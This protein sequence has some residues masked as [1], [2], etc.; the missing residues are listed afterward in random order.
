MPGPG[1][2]LGPYTIDAH[3]GSGG[4]ATVFRA[5]DPH[6][7]A[8]ALKMLHP[9]R[10]VDEEVR[11]FHREA[12]ALGRLSH[13]NVLTVF[14][15][16]IADGY[17]WLAME[18]VEGT[19]L[20]VLVEKW[21]VERPPDRFARVE[22]ILRGLCA[23][24]QYVHE[25]GLVHR[26]L[27]PG[28]VLIGRDGV[29][30][31]A[32]FGVVKDSRAVTTQLT[33]AGKLVGT[34]AFMAPEQITGEQVDARADLYAL[35]AVL[36][37]MLTGKRPI[38]AQS[39]AGYL[40][41]HLTETP[42]PPSE[43]DPAVPR[44]L[45][46]VCQRL[47]LKDPGQR[48]PSAMAVLEALERPEDPGALPPRGRE[49]EIGEWT[50]RL[51]QLRKGAGGLLVL[52]GGSGAGKSH[53]LR[54]LLELARGSGVPT[55]TG[56]VPPKKQPG[57]KVWA[58]DD[59]DGRPTADIEALCRT[60]RQRVSQE[61][62]ALLCV[63][64]CANPDALATLSASRLPVETLA[65]GPVDR[66]AVLGILRDRG[67]TGNATTILGKRL[68][69]ATEGQ[70]G[71][72]VAYLDALVA[73][74]W[75]EPV[76]DIL[77]PK[78]GPDEL[79]ALPL[80]IPAALGEALRKRLIGLPGEALEVVEV[81]AVLERPATPALIAMIGGE[82]LAEGLDGAT[83]AGVLRMRVEEDQD[84]VTFVAPSSGAVIRDGLAPARKRA[85]HAAIAAGLGRRRRR[86]ASLEVAEH[87]VGAGDPVQAWPLFVQ[88]ARAAARL[89]RHSE[90][91]AIAQK[92]AS[93]VGTA[94]PA[95]PAD[96]RARNVRWMA[97][98]EGE[99][100]LSRGRW[101]DAV[102]RLEPAVTAAREEGD[103]AALSRCLASLGRAEYR[104]GKYDRAR[105]LL[106]E[107]LDTGD[108]GAPERA[109]ATRALADILLR[110]GDLVQS[111][112]LWSEALSLAEGAHSRDGEARARRG[113][114]HVRA[115]Q[116]RLEDAARMLDL[117][118]DLLASGGDDHVRAGVLARATELDLVAGRLGHALRRVDALVDLVVRRELAERIAEAHA[119]L[120]HVRYYVGE[121]QLAI[122]AAKQAMVY[123][124]AASSPHPRWRAARV[125]LATQGV[126]PRELLASLPRPDEV[127]T[128]AFDDAPAA[129]AGVRARALV[130]EN[131]DQA[132]DLAT[133]VLARSGTGLGFRTA[134]T[135]LDAARA[136]L[137]AG[138][139]EEA[140][141][142]AKR[143]IRLLQTL[144]P[145][146][147]ADGLVLDALILLDEANP[148]AR[149]REAA[150]QVIDR[151]QRL[152][153]PLVAA[154]FLARPEIR[155]RVIGAA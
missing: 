42:R 111:E 36:Y 13:P 46:R 51:E 17:P 16:G 153:P 27:K 10:V 34:V 81:L 64:T 147:S 149:V 79:R 21:D 91:L 138:A 40:A 22:R 108:H 86:E 29:P 98:L 30:K 110:E 103:R 109:S 112:A 121:R 114:A 3:L 55:T 139:R 52:S 85:L 120:A 99:A 20:G 68:H 69:E 105:P 33:M 39:V 49:A 89:G 151:I 106:R 127:G 150:G 93:I 5:H 113:L 128:A 122:E 136:L 74:G 97:M 137:H 116:G 77:R 62:E 154:S 131:A 73:D 61:G 134:A 53:L 145:P 19:D 78:R 50:R 58:I 87:L 117:T 9:S 31:I 63:V 95:T 92:V 104:R 84:V 83:R 57:P 7:R 26:D 60:L 107:A 2:R 35:G 118:E 45:E 41:R 100:L 18:L 124:R 8:V 80:P 44:K 140:K 12:R 6:G 54:H 1:S 133:W 25:Q 132:R 11:R 125:L 126:P 67:V 32:D 75:F 130:Y 88:A 94:A 4:V 141:E 28:N 66:R 76:S 135:W 96:E 37:V 14:D 143:T 142:A 102:E 152:L 148:D 48:Y 71:H 82:R 65:L 72:V 15:T 24:L 70:P 101:D 90:V 47:L 119:L 146:S 129:A 155:A 43:L 123:G 38:E 59:A 56:L 115:V 23:G 144:Q